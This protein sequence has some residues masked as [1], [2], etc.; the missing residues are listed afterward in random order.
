MADQTCAAT[1][2]D[3]RLMNQ[4]IS[5]LSHGNKLYNLRFVAYYDIFKTCRC[6]G[7]N[8]CKHLLVDA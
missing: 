8:W 7:W 1:M 6:L 3:H 4:Y 2:L 5:A